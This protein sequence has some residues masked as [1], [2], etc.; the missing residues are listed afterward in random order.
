MVDGNVSNRKKAVREKQSESLDNRESNQKTSANHYLFKVH[1]R[2]VHEHRDGAIRIRYFNY[3]LFGLYTR[4]GK[5]Y[6]DFI[7]ICRD[8][9]AT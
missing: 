8:K 3:L 6:L 9:S 5:Q 7:V 4:R 2:N 1:R